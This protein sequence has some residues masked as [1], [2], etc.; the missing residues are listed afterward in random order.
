MVRI[1]AAKVGGGFGL[2]LLVTWAATLAVGLTHNGEPLEMMEALVVAA[3]L[4][5]GATVSAVAGAALTA[6]FESDNPQRRVGCL[7]TV[8]VSALSMFFFLANSSLLAWWVARGGFPIPRQL[9][10]LVVVVDWGL[11]VMAGLSVVAI[12]IASRLGVRRLARLATG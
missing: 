7:G 6:D 5:L 9:V 4:A 8:I 12:V 10:G 11:P 2:V 1:L 3:W